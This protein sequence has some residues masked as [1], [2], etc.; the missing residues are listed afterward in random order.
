MLVVLHIQVN[1]NYEKKV[2]KFTSEEDREF[3]TQVVHWL[4]HITSDVETSEEEED[5]MT[6]LQQYI[7]TVMETNSSARNSREQHGSS[8]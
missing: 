5:S 2:A 6:K 1:R 7:E 4:Y 3:I 8:L